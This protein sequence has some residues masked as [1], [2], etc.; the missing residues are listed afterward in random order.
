MHRYTKNDV[1]KAFEH[2]QQATGDDQASLQIWSPG[3]S[4]GTRYEIINTRTGWRRG[5]MLGAEN[6]WNLI[7]AFTDGWL[8]SKRGLQPKIEVR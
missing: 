2:Y 1:R 4:Y 3:D 5:V 8:E 6:A 7:H